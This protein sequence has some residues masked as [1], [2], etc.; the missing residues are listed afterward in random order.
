[1]SIYLNL[2]KRDLINLRKLAGQQK[3]QIALKN[4]KKKNFKTNT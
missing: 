4:E 1:M 2:T 3:N